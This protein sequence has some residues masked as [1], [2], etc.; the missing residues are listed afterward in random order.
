MQ[1]KL[2]GPVCVTRIDIGSVPGAGQRDSRA[3]GQD[4]AVQLWGQDALHPLDARFARLCGPNQQPRHG[5]TTVVCEDLICTRVAVSG[6][7]Q[8][9]PLTLHGFTLAAACDDRTA[10]AA[11]KG[12]LSLDEAL[13]LLWEHGGST[14]DYPVTSVTGPPELID[15]PFHS[16]ALKALNDALLVY[17]KNGSSIRHLRTPFLS[18]PSSQDLSTLR[19]LITTATEVGD[20][21]ARQQYEVHHQTPTTHHLADVEACQ[22]MCLS[23]ARYLAIASVTEDLPWDSEQLQLLG[24]AGLAGVCILLTLVP[25][26]AASLVKRPAAHWILAIVLNR[27]H[28]W[29]RACVLHAAVSLL[30][31]IR[32]GGAATVLWCESFL[33]HWTPSGSAAEDLWVM[34]KSPPE[35]GSEATGEGTSLENGGSIIPQ[36]DGASGDRIVFYSDGPKRRSD[37][38]QRGGNKR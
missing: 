29:P 23:W 4:N 5:T 28:I 31:A 37:Q 21:V 19:N 8:T 13:E 22:D 35:T 15:D 9:L 1:I 26:V 2:D 36:V 30:S 18:P 34:N 17:K 32:F 6:T 3:A 14:V 25:D 33:G 38:Q 12:P 11:E 27:P 16:V 7:F 10:S 24:C 20:W